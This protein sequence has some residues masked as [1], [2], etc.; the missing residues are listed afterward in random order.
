MAV[1]LTFA[2]VNLLRRAF[3]PCLLL[4][5]DLGIAT[6]SDS[7]DISYLCHQLSMNPIRSVAPL[8]GLVQTLNSE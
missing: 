2:T 5:T 4:Q 7:A 1:G 8:R 6:L 3:I